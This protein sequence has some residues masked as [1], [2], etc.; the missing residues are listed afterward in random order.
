MYSGW[1]DLDASAAASV[2]I[3]IEEEEVVG[4]LT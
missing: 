2:E 1:V 4:A 3:N